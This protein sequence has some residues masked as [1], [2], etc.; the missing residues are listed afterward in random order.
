MKDVWSGWPKKARETWTRRWLCGDVT[1]SLMPLLLTHSHS[2]IQTPSSLSYVIGD[3]P[4]IPFLS[5][6]LPLPTHYLFRSLF[7]SLHKILS[8]TIHILQFIRFLSPLLPTVYIR[9]HLF[10]CSPVQN[11]IKLSSI[12]LSLPP[13]S[14]IFILQV[15]PSFPLLRT[16]FHILPVLFFLSDCQ[17][18]LYYRVVLLERAAVFWRSLYFDCISSR[19]LGLTPYSAFTFSLRMLT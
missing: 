17:V 13:L 14:S 1:E 10:F 19:Q 3:I 11:I 18:R 4:K 15:Y 6:F 12:P 2:C 5:S 9:F 7:F 8:S 16:S